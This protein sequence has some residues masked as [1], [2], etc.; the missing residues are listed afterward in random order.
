[1]DWRIIAAAV[2]VLA[3]AL[4]ISDPYAEIVSNVQRKLQALGFDAG[5]INGDFDAKTQAA[6]AQF[7]ISTGIPASGQL[8]DATLAQL[9][10]QR[11]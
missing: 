8:D 4:T 3:P 7:Q 5:P 11:Q 10:V 1:M 9:E 6:L 2:L